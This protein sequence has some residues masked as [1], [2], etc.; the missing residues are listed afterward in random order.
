[1]ITVMIMIMIMITTTMVN[2]TIAATPTA[3]RTRMA[4]TAIAAAIITTMAKLAAIMT[5]PRSTT[6]SISMLTMIMPI[7]PALRAAPSIM[8]AAWPACMSKA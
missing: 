8:A 5:I 6:M 4:A 2:M 1:M 3:M 7:R